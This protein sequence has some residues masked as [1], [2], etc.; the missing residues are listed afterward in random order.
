MYPG[1]PLWYRVLVAVAVW[2]VALL[3]LSWSRLAG[4]RRRMV[5]LLCSGVG[6]AMLVPAL[7]T[8][9]QRQAPTTMRFLLGEGFVSG[10]ASASANLPYYVATG[11][12][13]L[14]GT[15]GLAMPDESA[16]RLD[17]HW[18]AAAVALGLGVTTIRFI[19]ER[20]AAP[21]AWTYPVGITWL[22][23]PVGAFFVWRLREEGRGLRALLPVLLLFAIPVRAAVAGLMA[24]ATLWRLGTHY[25]LSRIVTVRMPF[26]GE[27]AGFLP[28]SWE[29]VLML[30]VAPQLTFWV[31]FTVVT[32]LVGAAIFR[33]VASVGRGKAL[34]DELIGVRLAG[35]PPDRRAGTSAPL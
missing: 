34:T 5:A 30:A 21:A 26:T 11:V 32:G 18:L 12:C 14:L 17:R 25:D 35:P 8:E 28:G 31:G 2:A 15:L 27:P 9:G 29:Q 16:R 7:S 22:G 13:L 20:V 6:L 23:P 4:P 33:G 3:L 24:V 19:L 10:Y 1:L